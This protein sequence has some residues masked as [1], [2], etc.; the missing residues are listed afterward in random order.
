MTARKEITK[1]PPVA[2]LKRFYSEIQTNFQLAPLF[3]QIMEFVVETSKTNTPTMTQIVVNLKDLG[4]EKPFVL[5]WATANL[6]ESPLR[7]IIE[8]KEE[9]R[10]L[11]DKLAA[12]M[13]KGFQTKEPGQV[14]VT[15]KLRD[16]ETDNHN[17]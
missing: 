9:N 4:E 12:A 8:L 15:K 5:L 6:A 7:R 17:P 3:Q 10:I 16:L 14:T 13:S 1:F 2:E 11:E